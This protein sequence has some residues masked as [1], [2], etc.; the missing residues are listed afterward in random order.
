MAAATAPV[1]RRR[2]SRRQEAQHGTEQSGH[3][4]V[5][6]R[7]RTDDV[8]PQ[9]LG[10]LFKNPFEQEPRASSANNDGQRQQP[11]GDDVPPPQYDRFTARFQPATRPSEGAQEEGLRAFAQ[12]D[13][14][15]ARLG[16]AP[17]ES[18]SRSIGA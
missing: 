6:R 5:V 11:A 1:R 18:A 7:P 14:A 10:S 17:Q 3:S 16:C 15:S 9:I 4:A 2:P 13:H 12:D 8:D